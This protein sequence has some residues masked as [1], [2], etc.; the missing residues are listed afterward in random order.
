[1]LSDKLIP[2]N[3]SC[4]NASGYFGGRAAFR[5]RNG[6]VI[7]RTIPVS[8]WQ[9]FMEAGSKGTFF[10][11]KIKS[12]ALGREQGHSSAKDSRPF[13]TSSRDGEGVGTPSLVSQVPGSDCSRRQ[14]SQ[15]GNPEARFN[16]QNE[17]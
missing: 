3:S 6:S 13:F 11:E 10:R 1:M 8:L 5:Y 14:R 17:E 16:L 2:V 9:Q 12:F 7:F 4:F 15:T